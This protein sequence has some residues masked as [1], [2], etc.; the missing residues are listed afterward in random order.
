[1]IGQ[2]E[3]HVTCGQ[4]HPNDG[5]LRDLDGTTLE[6]CDLPREPPCQYYSNIHHACNDIISLENLKTD[7]CGRPT[8]NYV[9]SLH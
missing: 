6:W 8:F 3:G 7:F 5:R 2:S 4:V 1:M 9:L